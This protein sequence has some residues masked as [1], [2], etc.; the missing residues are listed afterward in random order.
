MLDKVTTADIVF[1]RGWLSHT[2]VPFRH[3]VLEKCIPQHY[4]A[5][6]SIY[7]IGDEAGGMYGIASG[8]LGI[9]IAPQ[10]RGPYTALFATPGTWFG[11][12]CA[13]TRQPRKV[14]LVATRDSDLLHLPLRAID[15]IARRD[16]AAWRWFGLVTI[17][18]L[19]LALG[20][21]DDLMTRDHAQRFVAMLLRIGGCRQSGQPDRSPIEVDISHEDLAHMAN[22]AR[23]TAGTILRRLEADGHIALSYRRIDILAP[24]ALRAM[25]RA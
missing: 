21:V 7:A 20:G 8:G 13:F 15:D 18:H 10:E 25:L 19:N 11:E 22:V 5:G 24:A 16:P 9:S 6:Q 12:I 14:G 2:P 3:A 1:S 23:T 4:K 17:E